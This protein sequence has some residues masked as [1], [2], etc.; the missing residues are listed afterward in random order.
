EMGAT[1]PRRRVERG[2]THI[3]FCLFGAC[4]PPDRSCRRVGSR[5]CGPWSGA[6]QRRQGDLRQPRRGRR[7]A[8]AAVVTSGTVWVGSQLGP[9]DWR[10]G[11]NEHTEEEVLR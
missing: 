4:S 7:D 6:L 5:P 10:H 1:P 8:S 9:V 3:H 11:A 2:W